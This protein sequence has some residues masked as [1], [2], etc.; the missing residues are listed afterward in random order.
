VKA[1][2]HEIIPIKAAP[3]PP[4]RVARP[5]P[6]PGLY[7]APPP[8]VGVSPAGMS[9]SMPTAP[10]P[11]AQTPAVTL[12]GPTPIAPPPGLQSGSA[13]GQ[14]SSDLPGTSKC[15]RCEDLYQRVEQLEI[16]STAADTEIQALKLELDVVYALQVE[17]HSL[18]A[19]LD[20]IKG[21]QSLHTTDEEEAFSV[22]VDE[23][24]GETGIPASKDICLMD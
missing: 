11:P 21:E 17:I 6:P 20:V 1:H 18:R 10:P 13:L 7:A 5:K 4:P 19:E 12:P 8:P 15:L 9:T 3:C 24:E 16:I 14:G 22:A 23:H 2:D